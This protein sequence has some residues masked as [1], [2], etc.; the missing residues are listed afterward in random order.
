[1]KKVIIFGVADT[2]QLAYYYLKNDSAYDVVAFTVNEA[3]KK[4]DS[5]EGL[6]LH[7]FEEIVRIC[8]PDD[9][10]LFIPM[11]GKK[12]NQ[13]REQVYN[14]SK[15][16]GYN[17][18]SYVSSKASIFNTRIGENCFILENNTI[19]PFVDI[20]NNV[21]LWSGN[22]IGHHSTI[23]DHT[24]F[25][26]QVTLSG[27]CEV[28]TNCWFGVNSTIIDHCKLAHGTLV[29]MGANLGLKETEE[30]GIYV[31]NPAQRKGKIPSYKIN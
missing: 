9:F 4:Q 26:S 24:F 16:L 3:F 28:S 30:W 10:D 5:F 31:G 22:H 12:M 15:L 19:Q 25:T 18:I 2:A 11:T 20:G 1:M 23:K 14:Q 6:P 21:T 8:P 7:S 17:L 13:L 29:G 27:H